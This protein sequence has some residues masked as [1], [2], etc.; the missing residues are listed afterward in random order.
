M[1]RFVDVFVYGVI[2]SLFFFCL[3]PVVQY[4]LATPLSTIA[5]VVNN[6]DQYPTQP[7][8]IRHSLSSDEEYAKIITHADITSGLDCCNSSNSNREESD[9]LTPPSLL[10][11]TILINYN[12]LYCR[13]HPVLKCSWKHQFSSGLGLGRD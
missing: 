8:T 6:A 11:M 10:F 12:S 2:F 3:N 4:Y 13:R 1:L 7:K 9:G 5:A